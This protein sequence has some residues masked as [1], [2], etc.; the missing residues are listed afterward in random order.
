MADREAQNPVQLDD[1]YRDVILDHYR[2][3]R[4][5]GAL[6]G[7]SLAAEGMN[8]SCGDE[9]RIAV[10]LDDGHVGAARFTGAGCSISQCSASMLTD[11]VTGKT[12]NQVRDLSRAV[13]EMLTHEDFDLNS[14][15]L[16][17]LEA[18]HG[19]ARFPVRIKCALLAWKVL[20]QILAAQRGETAQGDSDIQTHITSAAG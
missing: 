4:N 8:P 5:K 2:R 6:A 10:R 1:L 15:D 9:L 20:D 7:A 18:L 14:A 16:G 3:P 13:Q 17:E 19:V 12:L 11:E